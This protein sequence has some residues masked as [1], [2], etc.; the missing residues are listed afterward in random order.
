MPTHLYGFSAYSRCKIGHTIQQK[1]AGLLS[2]FPLCYTTKKRDCT[3]AVPH[4]KAL[5]LPFVPNN[6]TEAHAVCTP[7]MR[8]H[9]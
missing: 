6:N 8:I 2:V 4:S 1:K 5:V 9:A 7:H 3:I